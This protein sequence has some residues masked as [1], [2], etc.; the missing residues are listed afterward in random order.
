M[1]DED[2]IAAI[3]RIVRSLPARQVEGL[4]KTLEGFDTPS[5][6]ARSK[7]TGAVPTGR[8]ADLA[9]RLVNSWTVAPDAVSGRGLAVALN[10]AARAVEEERKQE[11]IEIVWTGPR[12]PD[13]PVRLTREALLEVIAAATHEL[14]I[15]SFAA[16]QV[17]DIV[18]ALTAAAEAGVKIRLIL[19]TAQAQGGTL[20]FAAASAFAE[21]REKVSFYVWP[22]EK[23][24]ALEHGRPALHAKAA[25][26]DDRVALVTSANLTGHA[27]RENMELGLLVRGG[28][29]PGRLAVHFRHLMSDRILEEVLD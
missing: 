25:I 26:A 1:T 2:L 7:A 29:I 9:A 5:T 22:L 16:Y 6:E 27:I 21:L 13:I 28:P 8:F 14:M 19:E 4:A 24:P 3:E 10:A 15:V 20:T 17:Q 12:T 23:R 11:S 18:D